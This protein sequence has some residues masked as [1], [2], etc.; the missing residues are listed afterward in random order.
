MTG[1]SELEKVTKYL[2]HYGLQPV[3]LGLSSII[4][5]GVGGATTVGCCKLPIAL[6]GICGTLKVAVVQQSLPLL[7][8][9]TLCSTLQ[10]HLCMGKCPVAHWKALERSSAVTVLQSGHLAVE[11][12]AFPKSGWQKSASSKVSHVYH[13]AILDQGWTN[14]PSHP[15]PDPAHARCSSN[16]GARK[17]SENQDGMQWWSVFTAGTAGLASL[18][19]CSEQGA[20]GYVHGQSHQE[21]AEEAACSCDPSS[22]PKS[23]WVGSNP[24]QHSSSNLGYYAATDPLPHCGQQGTTHRAAPKSGQGWQSTTRGMQT[25]GSRA[26]V[27]SKQGQPGA[28]VLCA[29]PGGSPSHMSPERCTLTSCCWWAD[30]R[31]PPSISFRRT[32]QHGQ[33]ENTKSMGRQ[34]TRVWPDLLA[35]HSRKSRTKSWSHS[36]QQ[37]RKSSL[38]SRWRCPTTQCLGQRIRSQMFP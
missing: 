4:A 3:W 37:E 34:C 33:Y 14:S 31:T 12:F 6:G 24:A 30:S 13:T 11:V 5:K 2:A 23:T 38:G 18:G 29:G 32:M 19:G 1:K 20:A 36:R 26:S 25:S 22:Y 10:M 17:T 9:V 27:P 15:R 28:H 7:L 16:A 21:C 8:P 35:G